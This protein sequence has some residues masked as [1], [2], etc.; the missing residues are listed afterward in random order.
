MPHPDPE[1]EALADAWL[2]AARRRRRWSWA[3]ALT[4]LAVAGGVG[5]ALEVRSEELVPVV[6]FGGVLA[7]G[8]EL[9]FAIA[10]GLAMHRAAQDLG[11]GVGERGAGSD[12]AGGGAAR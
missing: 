3:L 11:R 8:V 10:A 9:A 5:L 2:R 1:L 4:P 12:P 7:V 6:V